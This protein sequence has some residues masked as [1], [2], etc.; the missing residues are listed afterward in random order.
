MPLKPGGQSSSLSRSRFAPPYAPSSTAP[1][2]RSWVY[3]YN[4]HQPTPLPPSPTDQL[5]PLPGPFHKQKG[6]HVV[7]AILGDDDE[8]DETDNIQTNTLELDFG[9]QPTEPSKKKGKSLFGRVFRGVGSVFGKE[10]SSSDRKLKRKATASYVPTLATYGDSSSNDNSASN[11]PDIPGPS[12]TLGLGL[13]VSHNVPTPIMEVPETEDQ[14]DSPP[15]EVHRLSDNI[16]PLQ[17]RVRLAHPYSALGSNPTNQR[18]KS[19]ARKPVNAGAASSR[20]LEPVVTAES[21][22]GHNNDD[23][24][25]DRTTVMIYDQNMSRAP[26]GAQ[27]PPALSR[28]PSN[29]TRTSVHPEPA[30]QQPL[31]PNSTVVAQQTY[32]G[33][34]SVREPVSVA[35]TRR[36]SVA[37]P[38]A[39]RSRQLSLNRGVA[40]QAPSATSIPDFPPGPY[41]AYPTSRATSIIHS[42]PPPLPLP[43][44]TTVTNP[45]PDLTS[46]V[47]AHPLPAEDYMKM[48][49]SAPS[50]KHTLTT[51]N[52]TYSSNPSFS[53]D[54]SPFARFVKTLY[55][56]PWIS[57]DR[58]T[59]DYLP[60]HGLLGE[61]NVKAKKGKVKR[62]ATWYRSM[63]A[64][65]RNSDNADLL[66]R[67]GR[68]DRRRQRDL[69]LSLGAALSELGSPFAATRRRKGRTERSRRQYPP[70]RHHHHHHHHRHQD[71]SSRRRH[72][73]RDR[74]RR[75]TT[76]TTMTTTMTN[77]STMEPTTP[78]APAMYPYFPPFPIA[79]QPQFAQNDP[80]GLAAQA[81]AQ[82]TTTTTPGGYQPMFSPGPFYVF[83]P[84]LNPADKHA[85]GVV[86]VQGDP[87]AKPA[88]GSHVPPAGLVPGG[89]DREHVLPGS[90]S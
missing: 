83:Q 48:T 84:G 14:L 20:F 74:G 32:P 86:V 29:N 41:P 60:D 56:M 76:T 82:A 55:K 49:L 40:G 66:G 78:L 1:S 80:N 47:S 23:F 9:Y 64:S 87:N 70:H 58:V 31:R 39:P 46:P 85:A 62:M 6:L 43:L 16:P 61:K 18:P 17:S 4:Q 34:A 21:A 7:N 30:S 26:T 89:V 53:S 38:L 72:H 67:R 90:F 2:A 3:P 52:T 15:P 68:R 63:L 12:T 8:I 81:Q 22:T 51:S 33:S 54:L 36:T 77:D 5:E 79:F 88:G 42:L 11:V 37:S 35:P 65:R 28:H 50:S 10:S 69:D 44:P 75:P 13:H 73:H 25:E 45:D 57:H 71:S 59:V 19:V 24:N 27:T